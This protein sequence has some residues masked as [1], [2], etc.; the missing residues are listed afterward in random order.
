MYH[1]FIPGLYSV[2]MHIMQLH[3]LWQTYIYAPLFHICIPP[4]DAWWMHTYSTFS[5]LHLKL[6]LNPDLKETFS[7]CQKFRLPTRLRLGQLPS[8]WD[9]SGFLANLSLI[10]Q[11]FPPYTREHHLP[12][13]L[14]LL[15]HESIIQ[16]TGIASALESVRSKKHPLPL[17]SGYS[18]LQA[19]VSGHQHPPLNC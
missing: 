7:S 2:H 1:I 6:E 19:E 3:M 13:Q 14:V 5:F 11:P 8:L 15:L 10:L 4:R 12:P 9:L 18:T 16:G 17:L